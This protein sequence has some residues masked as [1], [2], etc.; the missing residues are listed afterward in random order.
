MSAWSPDSRVCSLP[1]VG[2]GRR[3]ARLRL[4]MPARSAREGRPATPPRRFPIGRRWDLVAWLALCF[5]CA[6]GGQGPEDVKW[7]PPKETQTLEY[8]QSGLGARPVF[9]PDG[10]A[11]EVPL[12][13]VLFKFPKVTI[14][15]KFPEAGRF[16]VVQTN[17][18]AKVDIKQVA[19][20]AQE[21]KVEVSLKIQPVGLDEMRQQALD[22]AM[23][24]IDDERFKA[25]EEAGRKKLHQLESWLSEH[26]LQPPK[27]ENDLR[28]MYVRARA[29][30]LGREKLLPKLKELADQRAAWFSDEERKDWPKAPGWR[31]LATLADLILDDR[32][33][34][35]LKQWGLAYETNR[36]NRSNLIRSKVAG[37]YAAMTGE[38]GKDSRDSSPEG[39]GAESEVAKA[40]RALGQ[41]D[42]LTIRGWLTVPARCHFYPASDLADPNSQWFNAQRVTCFA[43]GCAA[44]RVEGRLDPAHQDR[45]DWWTLV[46]YDPGT[47]AATFPQDPGLRHDLFP[48]DERCTRLRIVA[49]G[50]AAV[51]YAL[52]FRPQE[53]VTGKQQV[54]IHESPAPAGLK[55][56]Y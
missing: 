33:D 47:I 14:H 56:P 40:V 20:S 10:M 16:A 9:L 49:Q 53:A 36:Q 15:A 34:Q 48:Q 7:E 39:G 25:G 6:A 31:L 21:A 54:V 5:P 42:L 2:R 22:A 37:M 52:E 55:F 8:G 18:Q 1:A 26:K 23:R 45:V 29:A 30:D 17:P 27:K 38:L 24:V 11:L 13:F 43:R 41:K 44:I 3:P 28:Q 51:A 50:N 32:G 46:D 19:V 12:N 4:P 35:Y